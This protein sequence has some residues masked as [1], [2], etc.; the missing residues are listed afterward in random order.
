[1]REEHRRL[2]AI[3]AADVAGYS[4]LMT[5]DESGTLRRLR[6]LRAE[7]F[8]PKIARFR[9]RIVGSAG[10][11]LLVEFG[12]AVNAVQCAVELQR[13]LGGENAGLP[14]S[15]RMAFRMGVN[16]GDVIVED[17]TIYGDGVNIAARLEKLAEPGGVCIGRAIYDQV[18]G[19]LEYG[20]AD[21]G[22]QRVHNI[23][24]PIR[25]YRVVS[26]EQSP[27][28]SAVPSAKDALPFR[29]RPSIA[30]LPF[31]NMSG[32]P[33]QEY[34]SD[35]ITEDIIT[36]LS[37]VG[38]LAVTARNTTFALKG[39][40]MDV[41][42]AARQLRVSHVLEGSVRKAGSRVRITA[43]LI[44]GMSGHHVWA[45]R[46]D[47]DL[48][49]IFALQDEIARAIVDALKIRLMPAE[50][51]A[52]GKRTT[53]NVEAYQYYLMGRQHFLRLG[54]RNHLSARRLYQRALEIDPEY[55]LARA[56]LA[57]AEGMLLRS[58]DP[59]ADLVT[60]SA[61]AQRA[62]ALDA[63]LAEAHVADAMA[64]FQKEQ[65]EL[66]SASCRRAIALDPDLYEAHRTL[67]DVLRM[68]RKFAE[69]AAAYEKAAEVDRNSYGAMCMLWDCRKTLGDEE[70]AHR[71]SREVL[72]RIEKAM[73]LY[74][75]DGAAYAYGCYILH[76][77][78]LEE[79]ALQWAGRAITIDPEDYNSHYN[80]ACFLAAIGALEKAI[81]TL[82]HCVPQLGLQQV[83]WMAQDVDMNPLRD[84]PRYRALME[85]L[86]VGLA[87]AG[88]QSGSG[89][90]GRPSGA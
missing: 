30:V 68:E 25:A 7:V 15:R 54:R 20:Y 10:D 12:S 81:D 39:K 83:H 26:I 87:N 55:A 57:L 63:T 1:M 82:E 6:R 64:H 66:A 18:K 34:F 77:L 90:D 58:G 61:E 5:A 71:L 49:D 78:G 9:G 38:A 21:I 36:D 86:E 85:R 76:N 74:P 45:E 13:E 16:L 69:A 60:L 70:E 62:L 44:D 43:Q 52:I 23:A 47:R 32:D 67:G 46:Y 73:Q 41:S 79:R 42:E 72:T 31:T 84:H 89:T 17:D 14:E 88:G 3:L 2:A 11:S 28:S 22:E 35:G 19:K 24:E 50:H 75:D 80:V 8:E 33:E 37:K 53:E 4:R 51:A 59:S 40:S 56:G 65:I 48:N 29:N 27:A